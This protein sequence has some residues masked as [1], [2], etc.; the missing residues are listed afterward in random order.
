MRRSNRSTIRRKGLNDKN[1]YVYFQCETVECVEL[2]ALAFRTFLLWFSYENLIK[3]E[4]RNKHLESALQQ[5]LKEATDDQTFRKVKRLSYSAND[6]GEVSALTTSFSFLNDSFGRRK[7]NIRMK[8]KTSYSPNL[9]L[10]AKILLL[11]DRTLI[12]A[13]NSP[14]INPISETIFEAKNH[15]NR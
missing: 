9:Q 7:R 14:D 12:S 5:A 4:A 3:D 13:S 15:M 6:T 8:F 11:F 1:A 2:T 10:V